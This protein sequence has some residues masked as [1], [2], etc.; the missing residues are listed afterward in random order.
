[1]KHFDQIQCNFV[2]K[3]CEFMC[4]IIFFLL[5]HVHTKIS[6]IKFSSMKILSDSHLLKMLSLDNK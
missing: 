6:L 2:E 1:M 5:N 4:S 3:M